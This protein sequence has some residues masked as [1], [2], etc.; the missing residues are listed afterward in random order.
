MVLIYLA[1]NYRNSVLFQW[2]VHCF[3]YRDVDQTNHTIKR[4]L[5]MKAV[6][7]SNYGGIDV[8][9]LV[10]NADKPVI[11]DGQVLVEV[12]AASINPIDYK[13]RMGYMKDF[14][15][16]KFPA[17]I[18]GDFAGIVKEIRGGNPVFKPGDRVFGF[19]IVLNGGSGSFAEFVAANI[20]NTAPAPRTIDF[21]K[22]AALP[23]AG[24]SAIQAIEDAIKLKKGQRILIHGGAGGIGSIAIQLAKSIGAEIA[25]TVS[26][27]D[28][29]FVKEL[30]AGTV[31]DY[32]SQE[33]DTVIKNFDSVLDL[34]GGETTAKSFKVLRKGGV[35]VSLVGHPDEA[36]AAK[37]GI[38]AMGQMTTTDTKH[39]ERLAALVDNGTIRIAVDKVFT[40]DQAREA[41]TH[42]ERNHPRGKVVVTMK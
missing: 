18:G 15:P 29:S 19:A 12:E 21:L 33:F 38:T 4:G 28:I 22:A 11:G 9:E 32:Y 25:T 2:H 37:N 5:K 23:L 10:T 16:L 31:I 35:L 39:L 6:K 14:V 36:L 40:L 41:F 8:L 27:R 26:G 34:V 24:A 42:A 20:G 3:L 30:G 17:I 7:Y 1:R 13:V